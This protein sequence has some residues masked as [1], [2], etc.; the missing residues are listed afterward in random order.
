MAPRVVGANLTTLILKTAAS[1]AIPSLILRSL[2]RCTALRELF[3]SYYDL[4]RKADVITE[5]N[6]A[7]FLRMIPSYAELRTLDMCLSAHSFAALANFSPEVDASED[8]LEPSTPLVMAASHLLASVGVQRGWWWHRVVD[9]DYGQLQ[10]YRRLAWEARPVDSGAQDDAEHPSFQIDF[11]RIL[12][13]VEIK[14]G[15]KIVLAE[16]PAWLHPMVVRNTDAQ[17][18]SFPMPDEQWG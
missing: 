11:E 6:C 3:V 8:L 7:S 10:G 9:L 16:E 4:S 18:T 1:L 14:T 13:G 17:G 15:F 5:F 2:S 12:P